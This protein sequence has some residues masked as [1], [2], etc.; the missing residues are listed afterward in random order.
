MIEIEK[1]I[2]LI[3]RGKQLGMVSSFEIDGKV[4]WSSVAIQKWNGIYMVYVDEIEEDKMTVEEYLRDE[5]QKFDNL[6]EALN[7]VNER[8][9][10]NL[11][12]LQPRKG[13]K[14]FNPEFE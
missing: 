11:K 12:E 8:T 9:R 3:E 1:I 14:I 7:F 6:L 13:Q 4:I 2:Q 10:I 5:I